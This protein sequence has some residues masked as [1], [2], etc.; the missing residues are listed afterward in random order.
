MNTNLRDDF[1]LLKRRIDDTPIVYLDS[2]ATSLKPWSV[3]NAEQELSTRFTANVHRGRH[4]LAEEATF[5][6]ESARRRVAR[7]LNANPENIVFLRNAT[8]AANLVAAGLGLDKSDVVLCLSGNHHS[9]LV[10]WM[11][12]AEVVFLADR[13]SEPIDPSL[14]ERAILERRPKV[15]AFSHA[16]NLTG[17]VHPAAELCRIAQRHGVIS[18]VDAAQSAPHLMT[19]VE[20]LGCDFLALSGHKMLGPTGIGACS[21]VTRSWSSSPRSMS[22]VA[23]W[24]GCGSPDIH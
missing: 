22:A 15:L 18:F 6:Y 20:T 14:V 16:S 13:V 2:A 7:S 23:P 11:R 10:P 24:T 1:P 4:S 9:N 8:E 17:V 21:A 12:H 5:A 19:N 3:L